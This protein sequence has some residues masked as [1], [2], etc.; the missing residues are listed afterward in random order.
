MSLWGLYRLMKGWPGTGW[1]P[2]PKFSTARPRL[3]IYRTRKSPDNVLMTVHCG[4]NLNVWL[5][6]PS[7]DADDTKL[8]HKLEDANVSVYLVS[9]A[10]NLKHAC[11]ECTR[12]K[13]KEPSINVQF[14]EDQM[15]GTD[16]QFNAKKWSFSARQCISFTCIGLDTLPFQIHWEEETC[17][18]T[19]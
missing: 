11:R 9:S 1:S 13:R 3:I 14:Y 5:G 6:S 10:N 4:I 16:L 19:K 18:T 17:T 8:T 2:G 15:T 12:I 7:K